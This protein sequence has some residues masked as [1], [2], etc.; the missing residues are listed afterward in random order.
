MRCSRPLPILA[1]VAVVASLAGCGASAISTHARVATVVGMS[2]GEVR[3]VLVVARRAD[4]DAV[5]ERT[6]GLGR[7]AS[8]AA[9][10]ARASR[11]TPVFQGVEDARILVGTWIDALALALA[12]GGGEDMLG[13]VLRLAARAVQ[14]YGAT[15]DTITAFG[16]A[17]HVEGIGE[18]PRL[19]GWILAIAAM[20]TTAPVAAGGAS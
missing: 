18:L 7:E 15:L 13:P 19:P 6:E 12:A 5:A 4:L 16:T 14:L 8:L 2:L 3:G 17:L 11:W 9:V 10:E 1:A 20:L